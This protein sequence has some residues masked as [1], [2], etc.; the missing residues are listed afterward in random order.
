VPRPTKGAQQP[1]T[2]RE[3]SCESGEVAVSIEWWRS[4][5]PHG[6]D[7]GAGAGVGYGV[8]DGAGGGATVEF[9]RRLVGAGL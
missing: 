1:A 6:V 2:A 9:S 3:S 4:L 5:L 7:D 8:G